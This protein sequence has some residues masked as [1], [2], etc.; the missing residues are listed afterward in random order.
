MTTVDGLLPELLPELLQLA[1]RGHPSALE[2]LSVLLSPAVT[3]D[4]PVDWAEV[5]ERFAEALVLEPRAREIWLE[6]LG[7]GQPAL[8]GVVRALLVAHVRSATTYELAGTATR[9]EDAGAVAPRRLRPGDAVGPY[10]LQRVLGTGGMAEVW[11]AERADG[12]FTRTV[13]LKLPRIDR[14]GPDLAA[15]F[16][17]ERD[18]LARLEHP[19]I[20]RF[21]DAGVD[22]DG[23]PYLAMEYV[24][25]KPI[26]VW[27]DARERDVPARLR[28]FT[29]VLTAVQF[30]HSRLV[31]HRDLKPSN[32]L[33]TAE[34][35]VRL[36]DFGIALL[37]SGETTDP[38]R[39]DGTAR[40]LTPAY[41][42]P[43][44]ARGEPL[45]IA[46]DL[47]ALGVVLFELLAGALPATS[48]GGWARGGERH[49]SPPSV[50]VSEAGA[51]GRAVSPSRLERQLAGDLDAVVLK[52]LREDPAER[53]PTAVAL[54]EDLQRHLEAR[55]VR[56]RPGTA[57]YRFRT[58]V[59]R[60]RWP[61]LA[62]TF[63]AMALL[64]VTAL[65]VVQARHA[66]AQRQVAVAVSDFLLEI[67]SQADRAGDGRKPVGELTIQE[68][69]DA[70]AARIDTA[71][72][73]QPEARM[74]ILETLASVYMSL[75]QVERSTTQVKQAL[76]LSE[77]FEGVPHPR[78][79][80]YLSELAN[81]A[82]FS[83]HAAEATAWLDRADVVFRALGDQTSIAFAQAA[84]IRGNLA[85]KGDRP[86]YLRAR[87]EL[88]RAA[89]L[90]RTRY[91]SDEGRLGTLFF[92]AQVLRAS[93]EPGRAGRVADE[94]V[95][96]AAAS[97]LPGFGVPN[98]YSL[99][100]E[101][102]AANGDLEGADADYSAAA[103]AYRRSAGEQ[104]FLTLQNDGLHGG[105]LLE[106]GER[107][108]GLALVKGA[109]E[110]LNRVRPG[111]NTQVVALERLGKAYVLLGRFDLA[112]PVL[113][114]CR[115]LWAE[116]ADELDRTASTVGLA[117]AFVGLGRH[118]EAGPLLDEALRVR[119]ARERSATLPLGEVHLGFARLALARGELDAAAAAFDETLALSAGASSEDVARQVLA[120]AGLADV[121]TL[122]GD[123]AASAAH[124]ERAV[125]LSASPPV[126]QRV[127]VGAA[128][129]EAQGNARCH[130]GSPGAG[131]EELA[132]VIAEKRR[133]LDPESPETSGTEL[134]RARCL[135]Q[136]DR[137]AE[138]QAIVDAVG[139]TLVTRADP[140][141][142]LVEQLA[143]ARAD[144]R[145]PSGGPGATHR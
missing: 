137:R 66:R 119:S 62:G 96:L 68:A 127:A 113:E 65:A 53:Y 88:E 16:A 34:G 4:R 52:C 35:E 37:L 41:A 14:P 82:A 78:Q 13:A 125:G 141:P 81:L 111:S 133:T 21:Y 38:G 128:A 89:E 10:L 116:R 2:R 47:Y 27:C 94:A 95:V 11:L 23:Q 126:R 104:H 139:R 99:R 122:R 24:D 124:A 54:S 72:T 9:A 1:V 101:M 79:A 17:R 40:A 91:P 30:A 74:A 102:R 76:A 63:V 61:V 123:R 132:G 39:A 12:A 58:F 44:Q 140:P 6:G 97:T 57:S 100:A 121:A 28:L 67:L 5:R 92:L 145:T 51:R 144:L 142:A 42:S 77:K 129:R 48:T 108:R 46:S 15:R 49:P 109:S 93:G 32:I 3:G 75:D 90:F 71:L 56:A 70:A 80:T 43:E 112:V 103:A 7:T 118:E 29:Q 136:L 55:P 36:L 64:G 134:L 114:Q 130:F 19:N 85:R 115:Q 31:I 33:V 45:T 8:A 110:A 107:Q 131:E 117:S 84:K 26:T 25:G 18:I 86:D 83:G 87:R 143:A 73:D 22:A 138:A 105:V 120:H 20:A 50:S 98:A 106:R 59:G 135:L 60:H 69:V